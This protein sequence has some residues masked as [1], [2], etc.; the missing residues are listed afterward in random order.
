[1]TE[2]QFEADQPRFEETSVSRSTGSSLQVRTILVLAGRVLALAMAFFVLRAVVTADSYGPGAIQPIAIAGILLVA[3]FAKR[4]TATLMAV[5]YVLVFLVFLILRPIADETFIPVHYDMPIILDRIM[6]LGGLPM[7]WMQEH[8]YVS[9]RVGV[10][11]I[12]MSLV[13]TSYFF[14]PHVIALV[15]WRTRP[16]MFPKAVVAIS[17]AFL[18][19]L[20]CYFLVPTA[21]PWLASQTGDIQAPVVRVLPEITAQLAGNTYDAAARAVG[22]N[23]VAAMPSLHTAL[24]TMVALILASYGRRWRYLGIAYVAMMG[25]A[26]VYLGEHYVIDEIAG[27]AMSLGIWHLVST[28]RLFAWLSPKEDVYE[29]PIEV[30][31][32]KR[33]A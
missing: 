22:Q 18:L 31:A 4:S 20:L 1:M 12:A 14:A 16:Q 7:V 29:A 5:S 19:G 27:V 10:L 2:A 26:L 13:Y 28:H 9:G 8:F 17:M 6:F 21:P 25:T 33:A 15:V 32:E 30:R 3:G 11:D 24:T 23:D